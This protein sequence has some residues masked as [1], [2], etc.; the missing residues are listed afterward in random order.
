MIPADNPAI[1]RARYTH[2]IVRAARQTEARA[3]TA[4][5][6]AFAAMVDADEKASASGLRCLVGDP[7]WDRDEDRRLGILAAAAGVAYMRA[8]AGQDDARATTTGANALHL[9]AVAAL[10]QEP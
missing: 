9:Q 3:W 1:E 6:E 2:A 8:S 5:A 7:E 10:A 4:C